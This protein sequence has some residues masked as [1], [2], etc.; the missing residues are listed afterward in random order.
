MENHTH[1]PPPPW[2]I[3]EVAG[4]S[5]KEQPTVG[6]E[7]HNSESFDARILP[8]RVTLQPH[9]RAKRTPFGNYKFGLNPEPEVNPCI[10]AARRL[11]VPVAQ[12]EASSLTKEINDL[13]C[14]I[15]AER[16][17][18]LNSPETDCVQA[19]YNSDVRQKQSQEG[20]VQVKP[21]QPNEVPQNSAENEQGP[22]D[23]TPFEHQTLRA[24][25]KPNVSLVLGLKGAGR[26]Y[27][28]APQSDAIL[29]PRR[30][31]PV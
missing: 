12:F 9:V 26:N 28:P 3:A 11:G 15:E 5:E 1:T 17:D 7:I 13:L 14:E 10:Q 22:K 4:P 23:P 31:L 24:E 8:D 20:G 6:N 2:V 19:Q 27:V 18:A 25:P 30:R 29:H 21:K 16:R